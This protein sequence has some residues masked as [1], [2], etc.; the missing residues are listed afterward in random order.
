MKATFKSMMV[1]GMM[2]LGT[3]TSFAN[4]NNDKKNRQNSIP[5]AECHLRHIH[6]AYCGGAPVVNHQ[7][8]PGMDKKMHKHMTKGKHKFDKHGHC[9]TCHF[10]IHDIRRIEREMH[11]EHHHDRHHQDK[12]HHA[13]KHGHQNHHRGH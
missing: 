4:T 1:I 2:I 13:K 12:H 5:K 11:I 3:I 6:D 9:K 7:T 8:H 10:T